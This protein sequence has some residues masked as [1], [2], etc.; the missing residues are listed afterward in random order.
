VG[1]S[2]ICEEGIASFANDQKDPL[3]NMRNSYGEG[4]QG[5][6]YTATISDLLCVPI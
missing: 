5:N 3:S 6:A 2:L 1:K 4:A